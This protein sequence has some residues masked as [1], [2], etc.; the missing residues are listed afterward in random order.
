MN[1]YVAFLRGIGP[2][3]PNMRNENL[4]A[5]AESL[6]FDNVQTFIS[7]GNLLFDSEIE[8]TAALEAMLETEWPAQLG[9]QSRTLI[10]SQTELEWLVELAPFGDRTHG[11]ETYLLAT[12]SKGPLEVGFDLPYQP[13]GRDLWV[14]NA[15][16]QEVFIVTDT[17]SRSTPDVM[18]WLEKEFGRDISSRTWLTV[19]RVLKKMRAS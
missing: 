17:T 15:T 10:R 5:V 19:H 13:P 12:F 6:G 16:Q 18:A 1:R 2:S 3:N 7:S 9:F 11:P 14:V 4:M 8:D